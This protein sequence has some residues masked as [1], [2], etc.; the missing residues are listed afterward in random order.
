MGGEAMKKSGTFEWCKRSIDG[1][2]YVEDDDGSGRPRCHRNDENVEECG[3]WFIQV[4]V[5]SIN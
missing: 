3:I 5:L 4:D 2:D 1:R